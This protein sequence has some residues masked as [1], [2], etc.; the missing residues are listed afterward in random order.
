MCKHGFLFAM[1]L[2]I[3]L[4]LGAC[5]TYVPEIQEFP[6]KPADGQLLVQAIVTNVACEVQNAV[7]DVISE[8]KEDYRNGVVAHRHTR[9][10][11]GWGAQMTLTLTV[12]ETSSINPAVSWMPPSPANAIFNLNGAGTLSAD[13][14]RTE[15]LNSNYTVQDLVAARRCSPA[16]R[17]GGLFLLQSDLKLKE[18]LHDVIMLQGTGEVVFPSKPNVISH[19]VKFVVVS[20]G[21]ITP[22]WKLTTVAINQ[23]GSFLSAGRTRTHDL[24]ITLGP[25]DQSPMAKGKKTPS[26]AAANSHLASQIGLAVTNGIRSG[27]VPQ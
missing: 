8:D 12:D 25:L 27:L 11:D 22:A 3:A 2:G 26:T 24:L 10:L 6:G 20:S 1:P 16:D 21:N 7:Y 17:P 4:T 23:N 5:G 19:E 18:W 14:T 13:A 9:F 15:I